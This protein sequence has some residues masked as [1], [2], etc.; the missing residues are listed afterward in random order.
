MSA[1]GVTQYPQL[2]IQII[3]LFL[4]FMSLIT[5]GIAVFLNYYFMP[6]R[7]AFIAI[8]FTVPLFFITSRPFW[9]YKTQYFVLQLFSYSLIPVRMFTVLGV[10]SICIWLL[11]NANDTVFRMLLYGLGCGI[12]AS[13]GIYQNND[14]GLFAAVGVGAAIVFQPF[15]SWQKRISLAIIFLISTIIGSVGLLVLNTDWTT[16]NSNYLF[17]FQ[18]T[19]ASGLGSLPI[20]FPGNGL[21]IIISIVTLWF[22]TLN[23]Y[24]ILRKYASTYAKDRLIS[25]HFAL[26]MF[27]I[28]T[29]VL[30]MSYY[31]NRS[32]ISF[33]GSSMYIGLGLSVF[34][35][36][37]LIIRMTVHQPRQSFLSYANI[38]FQL[39]VL[40]PV[41][42]A[43]IYTPLYS[44]L[45]KNSM[46]A[47]QIITKDLNNIANTPEY[48]EL[49][50]KQIQDIYLALQ[51]LKMKVAFA[52][53][54]ANLVELYTDIPSVNAFDDPSINISE[55][56]L[57]IYC[58]QINQMP[59]DIIFVNSI[60]K[61]YKCDNMLLLVS[62]KIDGKVYLRRDFATHYPQQW[63]QINEILCP[64][65]KF[66]WDSTVNQKIRYCNK[67]QK[68]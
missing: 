26:L 65:T 23:V 11:R 10:G 63:R 13:I 1:F 35:L 31:I 34:L 6:Q 25:S 58:T 41:A 2:T 27:I 17:W 14:F 60:K 36:Y 66:R 4:Q 16:L 8:L 64:N 5:I 40:F 33:Q 38:A 62:Q 44:R 22:C 7:S 45:D 55:N 46:I 15:Q 28:T 9:D 48:Q 47:N 51:P 3:Y 42:I 12:I 53:G 21:M 56:A 59:Y 39:L 68:P 54:F 61:P 49:H 20:Q 57:I 18:R 24:L 37:Q 30:A 67:I 43:L 19:F 52:G 50:I 32:A 29:T